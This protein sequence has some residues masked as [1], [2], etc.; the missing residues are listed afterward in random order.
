MKFNKNKTYKFSALKY[1]ECEG[2]EDYKINH[3]WVNFAHNKPVIIETKS[4]GHI[5]IGDRLLNV[6]PEWCVEVK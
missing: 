5:Q 2:L 4:E 1:K 3:Q 6:L